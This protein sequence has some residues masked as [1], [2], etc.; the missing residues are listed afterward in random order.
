MYASS[1]VIVGEHFSP[2]CCNPVCIQSRIYVG[3]WRILHEE[4]LNVVL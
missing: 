2:Y 4:D 3:E 1:L